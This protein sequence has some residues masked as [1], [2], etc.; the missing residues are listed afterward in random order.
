MHIL[1]K[2]KSLQDIRTLF[3]RIKSR[4]FNGILSVDSSTKNLELLLKEEFEEDI[5]LCDKID[6]K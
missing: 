5:R 3:M 1:G 6:T 2:S 4:V